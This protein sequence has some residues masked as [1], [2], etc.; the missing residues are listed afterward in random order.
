MRRRKLLPITFNGMT[1]YTR[2]DVERVFGIKYKTFQ[3]RVNR[4]GM[5]P[6][7]AISHPESLRYGPEPVGVGGVTKLKSGYAVEKISTSEGEKYP[8]VLTLTN[9]PDKNGNQWAYQHRLVWCRNN[10]RDL[11]PDENI[12]HV[13]GDRSDNRIENLELWSKSQPA[14]QRVQDKVRWAREILSV[15]GEECPA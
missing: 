10:G 11:L 15:Y 13:N 3:V 4:G 5:T 1:A 12:H 9:D 7:E 2:D 6:H 8:S 14:G